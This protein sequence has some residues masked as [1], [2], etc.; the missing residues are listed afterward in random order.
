[1]KIRQAKHL[2]AANPDNGYRLELAQPQLRVQAAASPDC[3]AGVGAVIASV[4]ISPG[5]AVTA[6]PCV[7]CNF[8]L[9]R[10]CKCWQGQVQPEPS[11]RVPA[12]PFVVEGGVEWSFKNERS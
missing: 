1:M 9:H 2:Q 7:C 11:L 3:T 10:C 5:N 6:S 4:I 8:L 12:A